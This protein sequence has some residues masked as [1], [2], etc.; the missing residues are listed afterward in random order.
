MRF[1]T[2]VF[3]ATLEGKCSNDLHAIVVELVPSI[4]PDVME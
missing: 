3:V 1:E 4:S 2:N